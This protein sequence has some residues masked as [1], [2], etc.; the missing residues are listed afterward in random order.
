MI[1][2]LKVPGWLPESTQFSEEG[3]GVHY[4]LYAEARY[5]FLNDNPH[6]WSWAVLCSSLI[7]RNR[8]VR[9]KHPIVLERLHLESKTDDV[10]LTRPANFSVG[11]MQPENSD[12]RRLKI[13]KDVLSHI[14]VMATVPE[15]AD[16]HGK[17][18][19]VTVRI[20]TEK[21]AK[22]ECRRIRLVEVSADIKQRETYR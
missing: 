16:I 1:F 13:P 21:L 12:H 18:L 2:N 11:P 3:C 7:S 22:E 5:T 4:T 8:T 20:R 9:S 15:L 10:R 6:T 14:K 17:V 19:P